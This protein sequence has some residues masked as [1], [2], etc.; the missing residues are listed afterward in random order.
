MKKI[1]IIISI[2]LLI[3]TTNC[4][5]NSNNSNHNNDEINNNDNSN[6][7]NNQ[8][9]TIKIILNDDGFFGF[10]SADDYNEWVFWF[11]PFLAF[12]CGVLL[13]MLRYTSVEQQ[14]IERHYA[15][16]ISSSFKDSKSMLRPSKLY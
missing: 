2:F 15:S 12:A 16:P 14:R 3:F 13:P 11:L 5:C 1:L 7:E 9:T 10:I 8:S 4:K 6:N